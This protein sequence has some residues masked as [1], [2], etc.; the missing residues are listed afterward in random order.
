MFTGIVEELGKVVAIEEQP[1]AV[2]EFLDATNTGHQNALLVSGQIVK[3]GWQTRVINVSVLIAPG[4]TVAVPVSCVEQGRWNGDRLFRMGGTFASRRVR[5]EK[6]AS[7]AA[8]MRLFRSR[9]SDQ[10]SVWRSVDGELERLQMHSN[11]RS[12]EGIENMLEM[13]RY[14]A[15][16]PDEMRAADITQAT[17]R[18]RELGPLPEQCG[19][20]VC[21]GRQVVSAELFAAPEML[22]AHWD[23]LVGAFM[24]DAPASIPTSRPSATKALRFLSRLATTSATLSAGVSLGTEVHVHT[25]R[26]V[27]QAL[28]A[29]GTV[30][31]ASAFS[32]AA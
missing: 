4:D 23:A 8:N 7:V 12:L 13:D 26:M 15:E 32:L 29:D 6:D 1:D 5:R 28:V 11:T 20:V 9:A 25:A 3:G 14:L 19:V 27:A 21:H 24:L 16:S 22:A 10:L 17:D 31:H 30:L 18:L 2:V